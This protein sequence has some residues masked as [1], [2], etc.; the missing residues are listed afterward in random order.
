MFM[1]WAVANLSGGFQGSD[2]NSG[3]PLIPLKLMP[4]QTGAVPKFPNGH[5]AYLIRTVASHDTF[6]YLIFCG[7]VTNPPL[8]IALS[9]NSCVV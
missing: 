5:D 7:D 6:I 1:C 8:T 2:Q 3:L 4:L 9:E